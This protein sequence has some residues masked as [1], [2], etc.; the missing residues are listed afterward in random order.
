MRRNL[1]LNTYIFCNRQE[2]I[3]PRLNTLLPVSKQF[4]FLSSPNHVQPYSRNNNRGGT[5]PSTSIHREK[6]TEQRGSLKRLLQGGKINRDP[7]P[8]SA[9]TGKQYVSQELLGC[10][11]ATLEQ[12]SIGNGLGIKKKKRGRKLPLFF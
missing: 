1:F 10:P 2:L 11:L 7:S 12:R 3:T 4:Q 9:F 6:N 5:H 8:F